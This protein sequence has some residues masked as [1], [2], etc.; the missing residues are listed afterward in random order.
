[1]SNILSTV[2]LLHEMSLTKSPPAFS[3]LSAQQRSIQ[4]RTKG[5]IFRASY[6]V[7]NASLPILS[8]LPKRYKRLH[9]TSFH[10]CSLINYTFFKK[11][12]VICLCTKHC[13]VVINIFLTKPSQHVV[14]SYVK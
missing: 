12:S 9:E 13:G 5:Y 7:N 1:M 11:F 4:K 6:S 10:E 8:E 14:L 2:L 3:R